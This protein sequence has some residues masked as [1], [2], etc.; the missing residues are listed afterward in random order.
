LAVHLQ[1]QN[2]R[3]ARFKSGAIPASDVLLRALPG[4]RARI[5]GIWGERDAFASSNLEDRRR[6]LAAVQPDLDFRVVQGA[7]HWAIYEAAER[8]NADLMEMLSARP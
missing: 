1:M 7:G 5:G 8:V 6:I 3:Q 2:N 4:I